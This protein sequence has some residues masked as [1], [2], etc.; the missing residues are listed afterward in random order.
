MAKYH[1]RIGYTTQR[2]GTDIGMDV[3]AFGPDE[4]EEIAKDK[5]IKPYAARTWRY[6]KVSERG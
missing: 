3:D 5:I 4:A 1:V 6:T 2:G